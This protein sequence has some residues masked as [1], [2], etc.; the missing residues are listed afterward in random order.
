MLFGNYQSEMNEDF[1]NLCLRRIREQTKK[2]RFEIDSAEKQLESA[3][4]RMKHL[5]MESKIYT[6]IVTIPFLFY[7]LLSGISLISGSGTMESST[8]LAILFFFLPGYTIIYCVIFPYSV[9]MM[10]KT[11]YMLKE[12][13]RSYFDD[14]SMENHRVVGKYGR[15]TEKDKQERSY[16][17]EID[18]LAWVLCRY[19]SYVERL[20]NME[21]RIEEGVEVDRDE[22]NH[23]LDECMGNYGTIT[24]A[25][26]YSNEVT[27][28]AKKYAVVTTIGLFVIV[29]IFSFCIWRT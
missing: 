5:G 18:K 21:Q 12:H 24:P 14:M 8:F 29:A 22:L 4:L 25:D 1:Y 26:P 3:E 28:K 9:Y 17:T 16:R 19:Y 27:C 2:L 20:K 6:G 13:Q 23:V 15:R 10:F 11:V 7:L